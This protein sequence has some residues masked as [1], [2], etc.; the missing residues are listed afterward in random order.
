MTV[1]SPMA[2][3]YD[4]RQCLG[5]VIGKGKSGFEAFAADDASLGLFPSQREADNAVLEAAKNEK[6]AG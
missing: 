1:V 2:Y 6:G 4:G 5:H 3:A